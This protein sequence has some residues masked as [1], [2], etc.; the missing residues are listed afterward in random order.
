MTDRRR[1]H[2]IASTIANDS[3]KD[4]NAVGPV[5]VRRQSDWTKHESEMLQESWM[6]KVSL[7]M[8]SRIFLG[9]KKLSGSRSTQVIPMGSSENSQTSLGRTP[10]S[11]SELSDA[12]IT[13]HKS[14]HDMLHAASENTLG[15]SSPVTTFRSGLTATCAFAPDDSDGSVSEVEDEDKCCWSSHLPTPRQNTRQCSSPAVQKVRPGY[16]NDEGGEDEGRIA[17]S[18][19]ANFTAI[20][21]GVLHSYNDNDAEV[22][23]QSAAPIL[24]GFFSKPVSVS[25][26][27][28][29]HE[30]KQRREDTYRESKQRQDKFR[31][32][33]E[34]DQEA[35]EVASR[36][37]KVERLRRLTHQRRLELLRG[38]ACARKDLLERVQEDV[39]MYQAERKKWENDFKDEIQVLC[40]AFRKARATD[41]NRP[42][43]VAGLA[44]P[45]S[46]SHL[47]RDASNFEKRVKTAQPALSS[48]NLHSQATERPSSSGV[49]PSRD[50]SPFPFFESCKVLAVQD[51]QNVFELFGHD[52]QPTDLFLFKNSSVLGEQKRLNHDINQLLSERE[53]LLQRIAAIEHIIHIQ[54]QQQQNQQ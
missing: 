25:K 8:S 51:S 48:M 22:S 3:V 47:E 52:D 41:E 30:Q 2:K 38:A 37:Q 44:L 43:T 24:K 10:L 1:K 18:R 54:Q 35:N 11:S 16:E 21:T 5:D 14:H 15:N 13:S 23:E 28:R 19:V 27:T 42:M 17:G 53:Q 50:Q 29:Q 39:D 32:Q 34:R 49:A 7:A 36:K 4:L 20:L 40:A 31:E 6:T 45:E 33:T 12:S 26:E 9:G 46:L